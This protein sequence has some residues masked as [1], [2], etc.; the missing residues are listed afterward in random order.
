MKTTLVTHCKKKKKF[1]FRITYI[2]YY[3]IYLL[4]SFLSDHKTMNRK[5]PVIRAWMKGQRQHFSVAVKIKQT[6]RKKIEK[7]K[8][9]PMIKSTSV[10]FLAVRQS[11][12]SYSLQS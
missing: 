1:L 4:L 10:T 2:L 3:V 5:K 6:K 12:D 11:L 7:K 8:N 9:P